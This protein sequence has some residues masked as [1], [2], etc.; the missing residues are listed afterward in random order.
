PEQPPSAL[1]AGAQMPPV[2]KYVVGAAKP[3]QVPGS[4]LMDMTL[5]QAMQISLEKNLDLQ[6]AKMNPEIQDY[7]IVQ[8]RAFYR[9]TISAS[10]RQN[11]SS[12]ISTNILDGVTTNNL[13]ISQTY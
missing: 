5:E 8:A 1:P 11:H 3:P 2:D 12:T 7:S 10:F 9:P 13:S 4:E 6:V